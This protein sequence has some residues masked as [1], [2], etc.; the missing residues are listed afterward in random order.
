MP[1]RLCRGMLLYMTLKKRG[2]PP[3]TKPKLKTTVTLSYLD[4]ERLRQLDELV[5]FYGSNKS[6]T[7]GQ[8]ISFTHAHM[9]K[10]WP[11]NFT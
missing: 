10:E 11:D 5:R 3:E 2:R 8:A 7:I 1:V 4:E 9:K 6:K